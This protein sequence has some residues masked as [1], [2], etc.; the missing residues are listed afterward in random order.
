M[1]LQDSICHDSDQIA[2]PWFRTY[3]SSVFWTD[4]EICP[5]EDVWSRSQIIFEMNTKYKQISTELLSNWRALM[6]QRS[7]SVCNPNLHVSAFMS[8][9]YMKIQTSRPLFEHCSKLRCAE[10]RRDRYFYH[11]VLR[12]FFKR[13]LQRIKF[14]TLSCRNVRFTHSV[15]GTTSLWQWCTSSLSCESAYKAPVWPT[16]SILFR[17][18]LFPL[19]NAVVTSDIATTHE[20]RTLSPSLSYL[21]FTEN[22]K[23]LE[24]EAMHLLSDN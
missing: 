16:S 20:R 2:S 14:N 23:T 1:K 4:H 21:L 17:N 12:Y 6:K 7:S 13:N 8:I 24:N 15:H 9:K 3:L 5:H 10:S 18:S 11:H 22:V 19:H